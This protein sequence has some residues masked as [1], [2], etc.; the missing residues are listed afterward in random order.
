MV[1]MFVSAQMGSWVLLSD[2]VSG[3]LPQPERA[4]KYAGLD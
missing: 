4:D 2:G 1:A 3:S